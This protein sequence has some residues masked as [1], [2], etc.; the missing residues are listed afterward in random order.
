ML[1]L[2]C[3]VGWLLLVGLVVSIVYTMYQFAKGAMELWF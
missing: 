3:G 2:C 1:E